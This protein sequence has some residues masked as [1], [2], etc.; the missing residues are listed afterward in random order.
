[1][2]SA[3]IMLTKINK[4]GDVETQTPSES[5]ANNNVKRQMFI[6]LV[7]RREWIKNGKCTFS[8]IRECFI[9]FCEVSFRKD[10]LK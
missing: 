4:Y 8:H 5:L 2:L 6:Y 9:I 1:M 3:E 10:W 7:V